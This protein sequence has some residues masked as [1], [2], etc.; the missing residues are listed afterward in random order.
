MTH[1]HF[2]TQVTH[3]RP[4]IGLMGEFSA[5][6]TTLLNVL[7]GR[8]MLPTRVTATRVP[9]I[10]LSYGPEQAHYVDTDGTHHSITLTELENVPL[11]GVTFIKIMTEAPILQ[12]VDLFDTPGISDPNISDEVRLAIVDHLDGVLWCTHATQAW[13]ESERSAWLAMP[14][15]LRASSTLL[16]TRS[17][18]L[19][20]ADLE[21]VLHRMQ[22]EAGE[23]FSSILPMS[24]LLAAE[25]IQAADQAGIDAS[26]MTGLRDRLGS[27]ADSL[28]TDIAAAEPPEPESAAPVMPRR[29]QR[30]S[31]AVAQD[32]MEAIEI[33]VEETDDAQDLATVPTPQADGPSPDPDMASL[34]ASMARIGQPS[35]AVAAPVMAEPAPAQNGAEADDPSPVPLTL[36]DPVPTDSD[37]E[38]FLRL[39][40]RLDAV[41][42]DESDAIE[43]TAAAEDQPAEHEQSEEVDVFSSLVAGIKTDDDAEPAVAAEDTA[44]EVTAKDEPSP[45]PLDLGQFSRITDAEDPDLPEVEEPREPE[46]A[47]ESALVLTESVESLAEPF[48]QTDET[49]ED[50][51]SEGALSTLHLRLLSQSKREEEVSDDAQSNEPDTEMA[52]TPAP[53]SPFERLTGM[54]PGNGPEDADAAELSAADDDDASENQDVVED[55]PPVEDAEDEA[56]DS[57]A[58]HDQPMTK[59]AASETKSREPDPAPKMTQ[60]LAPRRRK[61]MAG[62][63][64]QV[65]RTRRIETV[66]DMVLA[67][68]DFL[69]ELD[70]AQMETLTLAEQRE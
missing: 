55:D 53:V 60:G 15:R 32:R 42:K 52:D 70:D 58:L 68:E 14:E 12:D 25:S 18:A 5:G 45:A 69:E 26:G 40:K 37:D 48:P 57:Q 31:D 22:R 61:G 21:R 19:S 1:Q 64:R 10:W 27:L 2:D 43:P 7:V 23:H 47:T 54:R 4:V 20:P 59:D 49:P 65:I 35:A 34:L 29:V 28:A 6:K 36:Q 30:R 11:D 3:R 50:E 44:P 17:D 62:V 66:T 63:W 8:E 16:V 9:P 39:S 13:R 56:T 41:E 67:M 46:E 38:F 51:V 33:P 24:S